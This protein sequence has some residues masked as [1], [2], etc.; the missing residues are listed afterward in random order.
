MNY[1]FTGSGREP[2][3]H[4]P[5]PHIVRGQLRVQHLGDCIDLDDFVLLPQLPTKATS[6]SFSALGQ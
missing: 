3:K 4:S 1:R 2:I 6:D 5:M